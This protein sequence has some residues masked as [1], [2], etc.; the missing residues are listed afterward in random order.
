[1]ANELRFDGRVAIV[2]GAGGGLGRSHALLL[3]GL[4]CK[5]VV[6]DLGGSMHGGGR[7]SAPAEKV[8]AEIKALGGDAV[9]NADSVEEGGKIVQAALDAFGRIDIV[10]NN[11]GILRDTSFPK[12]GEEDWD[13]INRVHVLGA[14]RVTHAAWNHMRDAGYGRIIFTSSGA[15]I[16]GNFGQA[17]YSTAK[18][19]LVGLSNTLALEGR[20]RNIFVNAIAPVAGSRLTETVLPK[21]IIDALKP[22]LVSPLV[23]YL[24]HES[25][26]ETGGLF[27]VGGGVFNK[28]RWERT[29]GKTFKLG[30][31]IT[32]DA[33]AKAWPEIT[34]F[35][36]ATHPPDLTTSMQP[37]LEN[38]QKKSLG[39]NDLIDVDLALGYELPPIESSYTE[40]DLAL[41][42]LGVGIGN[43]PLDP[44]ELQ[45]VYEMHPD[46]FRA[47]PTF[48]VIP[49]I[50]AVLEM[51]KQGKTAPG[52]NY[53]FD[54][55]LHGEQYTE[56]K[57]PLPTS[58]KLV[59]KARIK[60][61]WDKGRH[62]VVVTETR[63]YDESGEELMTNELTMLVRGAGGWGGERGPTGEI[64]VPPER[65]PDASTEEKI[66]ESQA[67]LYRLSG[68]WNPLHAD[69]SFAK[70]F[71]F[72]RPIL[73]G[74]C[75]F[76]YAA[77]AVIKAFSGNDPRFFKSIRVRFADS[78]YPG[79][80]LITEMW[81]ESD[82]KIVFRC[83]IKERDKVVI[84]NA[85]VELYAEIP[86]AK[87]KAAPAKAAAPAGAAP[88]AAAAPA[89][90]EITSADIFAG[91]KFYV[92]SHPE[93]VSQV[94][95]VFQFKLTSPDSAWAIDVKNGKGAVTSAVVEGADVT[96]ELS[97]ADFLGMA[98]GKLNPQKLYF[99]G[100]LKISG[101]VMA[102]QKLDFLQKIDPEQVKKAM[103]ARGA[104]APAVTAAPAAAPADDG[105]LT[106]GDVFVAIRDFL[107]KNPETVAK[108]ATVFQ[109]ELTAPAS[110]WLIDV[111]NGAGSVTAG[112]GAADV[113]LTLSDE[114]FLAMTS[115]AA[116][117]QKLYFGGKLKID[118]N[119]MA[120]QKL[121]FLKKVDPKAAEKAIREARQAASGAPKAEAPTAEKKAN[122]PAIFK[123]LGERLAADPALAGDLGAVMTFIVTGP[124]SAWTVDATS[125]PPT[126]KEGKDAAAATT[127][128]LADDVLPELVRGH[129]ASDLFQRGAL[130]VD[131]DMRL[132]HKL[133][134]FKGL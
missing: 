20:K 64:N 96:L 93:L 78:V 36:K 50:N 107:S 11:A 59:H 72:K 14:Y 28:L 105:K 91:V 73:H 61:I 133:G 75:T 99:A 134:L 58:A 132:A 102:S 101:N 62:A 31:P 126:V 104:A 79:E 16:Y 85:A 74:L 60:D 92:E 63:S 100:K 22:E 113:T 54:R 121:T 89:A 49:A 9:V 110:S 87:V 114:D 6:N 120:S 5:V 27:E 57:R 12:L 68:D 21:E 88:A 111:K 129:L 2:T 44:K 46:G 123:A 13:L 69:P 81:K 70:N 40:R 15:G 41:Y 127:F 130:R 52:L 48:A 71:G 90:G 51:A 117:P 115:G 108:V 67:L 84:N 97:D 53:G 118:G 24:C 94:G 33:I 3:G 82:T 23:A 35:S 125:S 56:I 43:D 39:G 122:A 65:A 112:K 116:D 25:S 124:D 1:M 38:L 119:V 17:N 66:S 45:Y 19:G 131:G 80:T 109:F 7:N 30:K 8:V 42:A 26:K 83:R 29:V 10:I 37:V 4:G 47:L 77:H 95:T 103:A 76:G 128:K 55:I 106:S 34:D 18:L 86:K 98:G 32:V